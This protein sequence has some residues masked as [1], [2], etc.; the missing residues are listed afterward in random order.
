MLKIGLYDLYSKV[1]VIVAI[2]SK[3]DSGSLGKNTERPAGG[4]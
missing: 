3:L 2:V 4:R 1:K